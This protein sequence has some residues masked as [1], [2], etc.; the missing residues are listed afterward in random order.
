MIFLKEKHCFFLSFSLPDLA[1]QDFYFSVTIE[2]NIAWIR[3]AGNYKPS[4]W[5]SLWNKRWEVRWTCFVFF[6]SKL[7]SLIHWSHTSLFS[8][9]QLQWR[10]SIHLSFFF[11]WMRFGAGAVWPLGHTEHTAY[12]NRL[13]ICNVDWAVIMAEGAFHVPVSATWLQRGV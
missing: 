10:R 5:I 7:L 11:S 1:T 3:K 13:L 12:C 9:R 6:F 2:C 8:V 4:S